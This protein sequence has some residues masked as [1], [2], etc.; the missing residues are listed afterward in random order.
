MVRAAVNR[1]YGQVGSGL[2]GVACSG[3]ADS[4]TLADAACDVCGAGNVVVVHVDHG[5]SAR[6]AQVADQVAVW[7]RGRGLACVVERVEVPDRASLE[8]AARDARYAALD[9]L[10]ER[11]GVSAIWLA[12]TARDQAETVLMRVVRGTGPAGLAGIPSA[13]GI[14]MRP[15]LEL[16]REVI[17]AYAAARALPI[18]DD[19]MNHDTR[20]ARVR[21]RD[22]HLPALRGENPALDQALVRL[23]AAAAE[24]RDALDALAEPYARFPITCSTVA[25]LPAAVRKRVYALA[26]GTY[27]ASH[28]DAIDELV[29]RAPAGEARLDLSGAQLVRSYDVLTDAPGH[30]A[31][32]PPAV[33]H[34]HELRTWRAGD[35]MRPARLK[36]HSR[37][38][39][40]LY[41]DAKVPRAQRAS[42]RVLVRIVDQ[43]IVWAE[44]IGP[45][46]DEGFQDF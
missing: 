28:L 39:S 9:A 24:W 38:L 43:K 34:G 14:Y 21:F 2:I 8:A 42:A 4:L 12:H 25:A 23:A 13:R 3:G 1:W 30:V 31:S 32:E 6:S 17:D 11:L 40:D 15:L 33:P 44:Y 37:K 27:E 16:S 36:G 18:V 7:C 46:F 5:L 41:G 19:P 35:R 45:A 29:C 10:A 20:F 22:R 26:L